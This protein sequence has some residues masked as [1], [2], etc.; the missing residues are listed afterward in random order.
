MPNTPPLFFSAP[1]LP[2]PPNMG[3]AKDISRFFENGKIA[4]A[5][6]LLSKALTSLIGIAIQT[7]SGFGQ[8]IASSTKGRDKRDI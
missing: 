5:L 2:S 1:D 6:K 8:N 3:Y 4:P 7:R